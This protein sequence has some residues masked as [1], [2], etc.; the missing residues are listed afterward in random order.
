MGMI[1]VRHIYLSPGHSYKGSHGREP[2]DHPVREVDEVECVAGSG[3]VGDRYFNHTQDYKGQV[4]FFS[5][6]VHRRLCDKFQRPDTPP[7]VY[8]RNVIVE[9]VDL[10]ELVGRQFELQGLTFE[11]VE[12]CRP[13]YWM[14]RAVAPGAEEAMKGCGGLRARIVKG[15][16]LRRDA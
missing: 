5:W 3:L 15:G 4:T 9:G 10:N 12:E 14:D 2:A 13:C 1:K 7:S 8:R 16:M 11:G 6:E